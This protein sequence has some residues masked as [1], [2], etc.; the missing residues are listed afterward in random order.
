MSVAIVNRLEIVA[1]EDQQR[2]GTRITFRPLDFDRQLFMQVARI[3]QAGQRISLAQRPIALFALAQRLLGAPALGDVLQGL[4]GADHFASSIAQGGSG[5]VQPAAVFADMRE[6]I[7]GLVGPGDQRGRMEAAVVQA[8]YP[9]FG[10]TVDYQ[11]G[12]QGALGTVKA[13]P[14]IVGT[15]DIARQR[16][17][18]Y[19]R[20]REGL[21]DV[22]TRLG[23]PGASG[24]AADAILQVARR[25][26]GT[27]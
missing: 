2:Q 5:K 16:A 14:L 21:R 22:R 7:L 6:E 12:H 3:E 11:V 10:D 25:G 17:D 18:R 15:D 19:D 20:T 26:A 27:A 1:I 23:T 24:R 9:G 13:F 8:V 4:D